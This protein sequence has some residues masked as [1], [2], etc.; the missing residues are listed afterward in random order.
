MTN[1]KQLHT[2]SHAKDSSYD[3]N[4]YNVSETCAILPFRGA[5]RSN[6]VA[7]NAGRLEV[8][9]QWKRTHNLLVSSSKQ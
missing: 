9:T 4:K 7:R 5:V 6:G 1:N 8:P 3:L 2:V